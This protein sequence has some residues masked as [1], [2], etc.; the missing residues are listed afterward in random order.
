MKDKG[1]KKELRSN[2]LFLV[3]PTFTSIRN[4]M[5]DIRVP[6]T[7][8]K[9]AVTKVTALFL[10]TLALTLI[11]TLVFALFFQCEKQN[12]NVEDYEVV[13][14]FPGNKRFLFFRI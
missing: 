12:E 11:L 10:F 8:K 6:A 14:V 7:K 5:K 4:E 2:S 9:S 3:K 13:R 1:I